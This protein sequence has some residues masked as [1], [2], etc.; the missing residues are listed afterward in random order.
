MPNVQFSDTVILYPPISPLSCDRCN[1]FVV[2]LNQWWLYMSKVNHSMQ[3][4]SRDFW[5]SI[6]GVCIW[7]RPNETFADKIGKQKNTY[8]PILDPPPLSLSHLLIS[9]FLRIPWKF[10]L[11]LWDTFGLFLNLHFE[12]EQFCRGLLMSRR[13]NAHSILGL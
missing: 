9:P 5:F 4:P 2:L 8:D 10:K 7:L 12:W 1:I 11:I 6:K 3:L 13:N